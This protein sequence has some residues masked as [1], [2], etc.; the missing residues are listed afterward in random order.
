LW[1]RPGRDGAVTRARAG[2]FAPPPQLSAA[3]CPWHNP[4]SPKAPITAPH[5]LRAAPSSRQPRARMRHTGGAGA[6][7]DVLRLGAGKPGFCS[8]VP[9]GTVAR[10]ACLL[11]RALA[12]Q[13]SPTKLRACGPHAAPSLPDCCL[14]S[15][16]AL[17]LA[18]ERGMAR[19]M[20]CSEAVPWVD[21]RCACEAPG[22]HVIRRA[23]VWQRLQ[24]ARGRHWH[25]RPAARHCRGASAGEPGALRRRSR[26]VRCYKFCLWSAG[27][28]HRRTEG[29]G[30]HVGVLH[31]RPAA[32]APIEPTP[33][34][35]LI[36]IPAIDYRR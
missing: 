9:G 20:V 24:N 10:S 8:P 34:V 36:L 23:A 6:C 28:Y 26:V 1:A 19:C 14:P 13:L 27:G 4:S 16:T 33:S 7:V 29:E 21:A 35:P 30:E 18:H 25:R 2:A 32:R 11:M 22:A 15:R 3:G 5:P 12:P 31:L 17:L